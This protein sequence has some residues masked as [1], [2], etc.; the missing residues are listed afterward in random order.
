M[1]EVAQPLH[2]DIIPRLDPEYIAFHNAH[3]AHIVPPHTLPWDASLRSRPP[4]PG[5]REV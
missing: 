3:I 1:A 2:P 5:S 4:V